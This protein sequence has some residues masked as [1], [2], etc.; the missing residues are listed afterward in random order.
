MIIGILTNSDDHMMPS[1]L[2]MRIIQDIREKQRAQDYN[3]VKETENMTTEKINDHLKRIND[4]IRDNKLRRHNAQERMREM[5]TLRLQFATDPK[6]IAHCEMM[7][8]AFRGQKKKRLRNPLKYDIESTHAQ[9]E[10]L[11][12]EGVKSPSEIARVLE[13][14]SNIK[15]TKQSVARHMKDIT[16]ISNFNKAMREALIPESS[17]QNVS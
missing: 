8:S 17:A 13:R 2:T 15:I 12:L 14:N 11:M 1:N 5:W 9:I 4:M 16:D 7:I 6:E 3:F 10:I